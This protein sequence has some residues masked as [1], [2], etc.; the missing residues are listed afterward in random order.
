MSIDMDKLN[1]HWHQPHP[2]P[3]FQKNIGNTFNQAFVS[4]TFLT[5]KQ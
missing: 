4:F 5:L 3:H 1:L 2:F